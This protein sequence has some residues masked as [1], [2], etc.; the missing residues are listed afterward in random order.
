[1][2]NGV[3]LPNSTH[4]SVSFLYQFLVLT[5]IYAHKENNRHTE[6]CTR[7]VFPFFHCLEILLFQGSYRRE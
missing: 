2:P 1:L 6:N 5:K 7:Y 3:S 4:K